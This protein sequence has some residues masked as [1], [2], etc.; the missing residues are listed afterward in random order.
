MK[1]LILF[2]VIL[3][4]SHLPVIAQN[5]PQPGDTLWR[6]AFQTGLN[7]NQSSFNSNWTG[8]GV[9]SVSLGAFLNYRTKYESDKAIWQNE[10]DLRFGLAKN[11]GEV[12]KKTTDRLFL[13]SKYGL[14]LSDDWNVFT[15]LNFLTQFANGYAYNDDGQRTNVIS[16]FM[17][18]GYLTSSWGMEYKPGNIF[19]VRISPFSPRITF[20][21]DEQLQ[22]NYGVDP[23]ESV[24]YEWLAFQIVS[25]LN[26]SLS[27]NINFKA[28]YDFYANY[29]EFS[30]NQ[31][32]HRLEMLFTAKITQLINVNLGAIVL[33]DI[34][35]IDGIQFSEALAIGLQYKVSTMKK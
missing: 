15:S 7:F 30:F 29:N 16:G 12:A 20:V 17:A 25:E 18:P 33:Y 28:R 6:Y 2:V 21:L 11:Q 3:A 26:T 22:G 4:L 32:D 35:Q 10:I 24:R 13:D 19:W 5:Q 34:D 9:N 1:K 31:F 14:K 8:G 27:D 23:G